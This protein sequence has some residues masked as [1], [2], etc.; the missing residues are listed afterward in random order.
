MTAG[1]RQGQ[2]IKWQDDRGFGFIQPTDGGRD[3]FLHIS[4]LRK[5]SRRPQVGDTIYYRVTTDAGK[6]RAYNAFIPGQQ[7][8]ATHPPVSPR[9]RLWRLFITVLTTPLLIA[10]PLVGISQLSSHLKLASPLLLLLP[11][12]GMSLITFYLYADDKARAQKGRW[13]RTEMTL[14]RC[15]FLG[16]WL[17]GFIAQQLLRHKNRKPSYQLTFWAIVL[18]HQALWLLWLWRGQTFMGR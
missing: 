15:E 12:L 2:L 7:V 16:G 9:D 11:Y 6:T 18:V 8:T 14:H 4:D 5:G 13:R 1:I 17:G 10:L 3:V